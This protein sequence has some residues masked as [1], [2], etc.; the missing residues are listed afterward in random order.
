[1]A[2]MRERTPPRY[3]GKISTWKDDQGFGFISPNGGGPAV[4]VHIK[5][6]ARQGVRPA[7]ADIVTYELTVNDKG[8]P[9]AANVAFARGGATGRA[10]T[11][12]PG[13]SLAAAG[14]LLGLLA[15]L[16][17][18]GLAPPLLLFLYLGMSAL[19]FVAY[20]IDKAAARAGRWRTPEK[21]LHLLGLACGWPGALLAQRL[22]RH[23]SA[24]PSFQAA[25]RWTVAL[26]CAALFWVL[27]PAGARTLRAVL[28]L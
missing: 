16:A 12:A 2:R 18:A 6:F 14:A 13:R 7:E 21:T 25:F 9:R 11:R 20:A 28:G 5:A 27:T 10:G 24:K 23:K 3:Q 15:L 17:V 22:L 8:Q 1:M 26:N 19:A 4:F